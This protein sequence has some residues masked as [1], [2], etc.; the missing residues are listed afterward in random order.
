[1]TK[2]GR[3]ALT[4]KNVQ[5]NNDLYKNGNDTA[6]GETFLFCIPKATAEQMDAD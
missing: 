1:M 4:L 3:S 5:K 6:Y 2:A